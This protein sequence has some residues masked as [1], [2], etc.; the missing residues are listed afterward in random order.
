[1]DAKGV[2]NFQNKEAVGPFT[3]GLAVEIEFAEF[4][5]HDNLPAGTEIELW[6]QVDGETPPWDLPKES[7]PF[8]RSLWVTDER[9]GTLARFDVTEI[10]K[11]WQRGDLPN[12]GFVLRTMTDIEEDALQSAVPV[13]FSSPKSAVLRFRALDAS[14]IGVGAE[15]HPG[16]SHQRQEDGSE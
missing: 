2:G 13:N 10:T 5:F 14:I 11:A 6:P 1:M 8:Y 3:S 12:L 9:T 16:E 7:L 15:E 4:S